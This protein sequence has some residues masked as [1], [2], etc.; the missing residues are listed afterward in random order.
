MKQEAAGLRRDLTV[1]GGSLL[2]LALF[3][4]SHTTLRSLRFDR[5]RRRLEKA[6]RAMAGKDALTGAHNRRR[7]WE[8]ASRELQRRSRPAGTPSLLLLDVDHFRHI[9]DSRGHPVGDQVLR[10]LVRLCLGQLRPADLFGRIGGEEFAALLV[11]TDGNDAL[12]V[13]ERLRAHLEDAV[14]DTD[15][16]PVGVTVSIG[17]ASVGGDD[18]VLDDILRRADRALYR[19]KHRGRN[20]VEA[21]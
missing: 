18:N 3:L 17:V 15:S 2:L 5:E 16:G 7:F 6:L 12:S 20:R 13:A 4:S 19:A 11:E 8:L 1:F 9:N 10:K 14:L 21:C